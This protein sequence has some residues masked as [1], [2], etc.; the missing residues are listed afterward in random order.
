MD[1]LG[2][3]GNRD[4][5]SSVYS[6]LP[7]EIRA[8]SGLCRKAKARSLLASTWVF[9]EPVCFLLARSPNKQV[10]GFGEPAPEIRELFA[11]FPSRI[12][13][14]VDY[15]DL[16]W[17]INLKAG[18]VVAIASL[19]KGHEH[20]VGVSLA[21]GIAI[22]FS[23]C[24][25]QYEPCVQVRQLKIR[26]FSK[27]AGYLNPGNFTDASYSSMMLSLFNLLHIVRPVRAALSKARRLLADSVLHSLP[28][29][30]TSRNPA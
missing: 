3:G 7:K 27:P 2:L 9:L 21:H 5:F 11:L 15:L 16:S 17:F 8:A 26:Y 23:E 20:A 6:C 4:A 22:A 19:G 10:H 18:N 30:G 29:P 25:V 24:R 28:N 13:E 1:L 12:G 14:I